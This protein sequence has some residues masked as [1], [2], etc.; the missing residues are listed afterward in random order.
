MKPR[1][2]LVHWPKGRYINAA[3]TDLAATFARVRKEMKQAAA[4]SA[5]VIQLRKGSK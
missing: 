2:N 3:S 5:P 4:P 1:L